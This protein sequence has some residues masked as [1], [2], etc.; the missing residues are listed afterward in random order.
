MT[1]AKPGGRAAG[2]TATGHI[3]RR[4]CVKALL[5]SQGDDVLIIAGL[6]GAKGDVIAAVGDAPRVFAFGGAMGAAASMGLGLALAQ[7]DKRVL[8][9]TGDGE[10]L[11]N[12]GTL[13][14]I[15][16]ANPANLG[17]VCVDNEHYGETGFQRSHTGLGTDLAAMAQGP[18][19]GPC[20]RCVRWRSWTR[21]A[22]CC[23]NPMVLLLS[24]LRSPLMIRP[25]LE[26]IGMR[27]IIR[28]VFAKPF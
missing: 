8:V 1:D 27:P 28:T 16:I 12:V 26:S 9:I 4:A 7:P 23:G 17:V 19:S 18:G 5:D 20:E 3:D 21:Q 6:A 24:C 13:A 10:L 2:K 22:I 11:M 15:A 25:R 14:T